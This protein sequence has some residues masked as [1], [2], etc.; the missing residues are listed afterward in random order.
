[1]HVLVHLAGKVVCL[2]TRHRETLALHGEQNHG[3][4]FVVVKNRSGAWE[5]M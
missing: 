2:K 4:E 1:M 5:K 3:V